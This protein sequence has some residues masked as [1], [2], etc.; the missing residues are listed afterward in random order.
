M[1]APDH[2]RRRERRVREHGE[3]ARS[4]ARSSSTEP[5]HPEPPDVG[6]AGLKAGTRHSWLGP[7]AE[8]LRITASERSS[9]TRPARAYDRPLPSPGGQPCGTGDSVRAARRL[10]GRLRHLDHRQRL[11]GRG[12]DKQ[13]MVRAALDAGINFIDTAP[14]YGDA[15]IGETLL[16]DILGRPRR[17]RRHD[18]VRLR[19]RAPRI[20]PS[21]ERPQDWR[22]APIR[23]QVETSL[24]RLAPPTSTCT[25]STTAGSTPCV[26]TR[27]GRRSTPS[28]AEGKVRSLGV[29]L[30]PAIGWVEEGLESIRDRDISSLQTVFNVLEQEPGLTFAREPKVAD[31]A[32]S[33]M[34]RVPARVRHAVDEDHA[35]HRVPTGR[36]PRAPQ[37]REHAGQLREGGDAVVP[38]GGHGPHQGPGRGRRDPRQPVVRDRAPDVRRRRRGPRVRRRVRPPP[39]GRRGRAPRRPLRA[40][41]STT[42]TATRC[43]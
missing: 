9:E 36:P 38:L 11:V 26:T 7:R 16:A 13:G 42:T 15:G 37:A 14:V 35:G 28:C 18:E 43:H 20:A 32:V 21:S 22:P 1:S 5:A 23:S 12:H 39:H 19:H 25:S 31:G 41:T 27:C 2:A 34:S 30:G 33:L 29:A 6:A 3:W 17:H 24:R 10:R 40:G 4:P 8:R